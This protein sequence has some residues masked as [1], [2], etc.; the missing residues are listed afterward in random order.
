MSSSQGNTDRA[1]SCLK[2][3]KISMPV[4]KSRHIQKLASSAEDGVLGAPAEPEVCKI[5]RHKAPRG[6]HISDVSPTGTFRGDC[7]HQHGTRRSAAVSLPAAGDRRRERHRRPVVDAMW[8]PAPHSCD[9][10]PVH[11][12]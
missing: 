3:D 1:T 7:V 5:V 8:S 12:M 9:G 6:R 2:A 11:F 10:L 4:V